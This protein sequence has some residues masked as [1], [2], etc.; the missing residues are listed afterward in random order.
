MIMG[1]CEKCSKPDVVLVNVAGIKA[2]L[3]CVAAA[4]APPPP[5]VADS[6][7]AR[8][9][10]EY[11]VFNVKGRV[12]IGGFHDDP[13]SMSRVLSLFTKADL[14]TWESELT[15]KAL[16][17][18]IERSATPR[19]R[20]LGY[21]ENG[22]APEHVKNLWTGFAVRPRNGE[23]PTIREFLF[24]NVA[25]GD[26][27]NFGW[28]MNLL[29]YWIQ[30]PCGPG[31]C[32]LALTGSKGVGKGTFYRILR[33]IFGIQ[34]SLQLTSADQVGGRF[35]SHL[36]HVLL[37]F[38]DEAV[39][40]GNNS[41]YGNLNRLVTEDT[42]F[43][44]SKGVDAFQVKNTIKL[45]LASN[46]LPARMSKDERRYLSFTVDHRV[47]T[48]KSKYFRELH[49]DLPFELPAFVHALLD[50]NVDVELVRNPPVTATLEQQI[51]ESTPAWTALFRDVLEHPQDAHRLKQHRE[52]GGGR[53]LRLTDEMAWD[54][55]GVEDRDRDDVKKSRLHAAARAAGWERARLREGGSLAYG[56]RA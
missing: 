43:L 37:L 25:E 16:E 29:A 12:R 38:A 6:L 1:D 7:Y 35:N 48:P 39:F 40:S 51:D 18:W 11:F 15:L 21:Y 31:L 20:S 4:A 45:I 52:G 55:V 28:L 33:G 44:E 36:G 30:N 26:E 14:T 47:S 23:W 53:G 32:A 17:T 5:P 27:Q 2:C 50:I 49:E 22:S 46:H 41:V 8:M 24:W 13:A 19:F 54:L 42:L 9:D 3:N 56:W 34:N 10:H